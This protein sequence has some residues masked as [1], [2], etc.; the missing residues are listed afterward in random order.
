M[1]SVSWQV[2]QVMLWLHSPNV[3]SIRTD[4]TQM[5]PY[6]F[7]GHKELKLMT[8]ANFRSC[9]ICSWSEWSRLMGRWPTRERSSTWRN[10]MSMSLTILLI[11]L[12]GLDSCRNHGLGWHWFGSS[13]VLPSGPANSAKFPSVRSWSAFPISAP[14]T[15]LPSAWCRTNASGPASRVTIPGTTS[16]SHSPRRHRY[17]ENWL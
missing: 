5:N 14:P 17:E 10:S 13:T 7:V 15:L 9:P 11:R 2:K 3:H 12:T 4:C 1:P 16:S 8:P 6:C